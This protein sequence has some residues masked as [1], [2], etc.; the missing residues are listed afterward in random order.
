MKAWRERRGL[1]QTR[2]AE[3][4]GINRVS[5][6]KYESGERQ[7]QNMT[8][9]TAYRLADVLQVEPRVFLKPDAARSGETH[10]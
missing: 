3:L 7:P 10:Q 4:S 1:T 6:N 8:L 5:I 2:L 9:G